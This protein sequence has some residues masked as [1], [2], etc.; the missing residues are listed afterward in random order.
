MCDCK[1]TLWRQPLPVLCLALLIAPGAMASHTACHAAALC[2][3]CWPLQIVKTGRQMIGATNPLA[4]AP[5]TIRQELESSSMKDG[6]GCPELL[7]CACN[8]PLCPEH[9]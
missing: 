1:A 8:D 2:E 5:G 4:S 7:H 9:G 6:V 3:Y